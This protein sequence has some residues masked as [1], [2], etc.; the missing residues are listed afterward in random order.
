LHRAYHG[1]MAL[2]VTCERLARSFTTSTSGAGRRYR[3]GV[4]PDPPLKGR[5]QTPALS[6]TESPLV[7]KQQPRTGI[8]PSSLHQPT[9][10]GVNYCTPVVIDRQGRPVQPHPISAAAWQQVYPQ[11][12]YDV[13]T[14]LR[15]DYASPEVLITENGVPDDPT[16]SSQPT[17]DRARVEFLGR[18]LASCIRRS[19]RAAGSLATMPGHCWTTLNGLTATANVGDLSGW[20]SAVLAAALRPPRRGTPPLLA[21]TASRAISDQPLRVHCASV[22]G[23]RAS[24]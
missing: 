12:L 14:R 21:A 3:F 10:W 11:G 5:H 2:V 15:R 19:A 4:S 13:L 9:F 1:W 16:D 17:A 18:H 22:L 24:H 6:M 23:R 8:S 7:S 20:I